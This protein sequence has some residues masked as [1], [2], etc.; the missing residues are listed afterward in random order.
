MQVDRNTS[1]SHNLL[2]AAEDSLCRL[3]V[4]AYGSGSHSVAVR[5]MGPDS[6]S[7]PHFLYFDFLESAIET[8]EV[9][10]FPVA[11]KITLATDWDTDHSIA[12][13]PECT[14]WI[15]NRLGYTARANHYVGALWYYELVRQ[16]HVYASASVD[17][18]GTP[19]WAAGF[20]STVTIGNVNYSDVAAITHLHRV[21]DTAEMIAKAFKFHLNSGYNSVHAVATGGLL[22]IFSRSMGE[23]GND[24][25][26]LATTSQ[27]AGFT[28]SAS[29][30]LLG[31][32]FDGD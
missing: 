2:I 18:T 7:D 13:P 14:A 28:V 19:V 21:G 16:W 32:G 25:T 6:L 27:P 20:Y 17:F 4:G 1:L 12:L 30:G 10:S 22:E 8:D 31:G 26:L 9:P 24:I 3:K 15:V 23:V 5:H 11:P 29:S